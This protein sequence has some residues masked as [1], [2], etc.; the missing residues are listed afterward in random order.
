M[1]P[2]IEDATKIE[3][4]CDVGEVRV[5]LLQ[6]LGSAPRLHPTTGN[7]IACIFGT[8]GKL[9]I[10]ASSCGKPSYAACSDAAYAVGCCRRWF[11]QVA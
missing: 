2:L 1:E 6:Q 8:T 9:E 5:L 10:G 7:S 11:D 4:C 3:A